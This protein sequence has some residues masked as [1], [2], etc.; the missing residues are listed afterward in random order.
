MDKKQCASLR[1]VGKSILKMYQDFLKVIELNMHFHIFLHLK[2]IFK[3]KDSNGKE[4]TESLNSI[5]CLET[6]KKVDLVEL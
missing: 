4:I 1:R 6:D 3:M 2:F 5:I